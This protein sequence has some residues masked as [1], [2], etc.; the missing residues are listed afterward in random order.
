MYEGKDGRGGGGKLER[1]RKRRER[2]AEE[3]EKELIGDKMKITQSKRRYF[4]L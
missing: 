4:S 1:T 2:E 3:G